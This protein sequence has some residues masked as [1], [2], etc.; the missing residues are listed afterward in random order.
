MDTDWTEAAESIT[1]YK[2][3][4]TALLEQALSHSS[5]VDQRSESNERLEFLG[6][7]VLGFVVCCEIYNRFPEFEEGDMTKVKSSVVS[8]KICA[9]VADEL[10]IARILRVGKGMNTQKQI[11]SSVTG[12]AYE[13]LIG[14]IFLD[15]GFDV[16]K[17]FV[18]KTMSERINAAARSTHQ[19]NYK[20]IL[21]QFGQKTVGFAPMYVVLDEKGPDH[22]KCFEITVDL[23]GRRFDSRWAASK[24]QAEQLA[25]LAAL[26]E[27]EV[28]FESEDGSVEIKENYGE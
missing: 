15:G 24:K 9:D 11:P 12:A 3:T 26:V 27:L 4:N 28:A 1:G 7:A 6:D 13:A 5:A 21:Q 18:L 8:R 14:A 22:A 2:F 19:E 10:E 16:A 25:A 23:N 20:S 17:T